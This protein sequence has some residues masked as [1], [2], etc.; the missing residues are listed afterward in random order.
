MPMDGDKYAYSDVDYVETWT[1]MEECVNQELT[2]SIGV[3]NFN[4]EQITRIL[5]IAKIKPANS[6]VIKPAFSISFKR[7]KYC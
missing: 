6:Q 4:S 3:S 5:N 2:R 1:A 7:K